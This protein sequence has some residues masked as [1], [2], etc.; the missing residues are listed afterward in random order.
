MPSPL[1]RLLEENLAPLFGRGMAPFVLRR[2]ARGLGKREDELTDL[3]VLSLVDH[4]RKSTLD[5]IYGPNAG[6]VAELIVR[7]V[8]RGTVLDPEA[9]KG[10]HSWNALSRAQELI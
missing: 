3:E 1:L 10:L 7:H 5:R 9:V 6:R 4:L 2:A 8:K